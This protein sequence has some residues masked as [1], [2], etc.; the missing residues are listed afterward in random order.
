M[1]KTW[2][3]QGKQVLVWIFPVERGIWG[4]MTYPIINYKAVYCEL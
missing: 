3:G 2:V 4:D 1:M